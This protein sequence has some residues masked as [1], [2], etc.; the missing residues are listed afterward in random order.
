MMNKIILLSNKNIMNKIK[1]K[2][3]VKTKFNK[4]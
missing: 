4:I 1:I 2:N 3:K